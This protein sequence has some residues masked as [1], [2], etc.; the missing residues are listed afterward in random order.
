MLLIFN[1]I[2]KICICQKKGKK[3]DLNLMFRYLVYLYRKYRLC[4]VKMLSRNWYL[5]WL[6]PTRK[7]NAKCTAHRIRSM[8][9]LLSFH[10]WRQHV[11]SG[12]LPLTPSNLHSPL[13]KCFSNVSRSCFSS[14]LSV[15]PS[16]T[17]CRFCSLS[18]PTSASSWDILSIFR[19]LKWKHNLKIF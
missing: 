9:F 12:F 8:Y 1:Y 15:S 19:I 13:S 5:V 18:W 17:S 7:I 14:P 10:N 4:Q 6:N 2:V 3:R 16:F 11:E